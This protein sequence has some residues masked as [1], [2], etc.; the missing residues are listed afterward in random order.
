MTVWISDKV[1]A[2]RADAQILGQ[3]PSDGYAC[4][5][6]CFG[7]GPPLILI[8]GGSGSWLHWVPIIDDLARD[9]RLMIPDM[10]GYGAARDRGDDTLEGIVAGVV[11]DL[12]RLIAPGEHTALAA[13]SFGGIIAGHVAANAPELVSHLGLIGSAGFGGP[14]G[15]LPDMQRLN[16]LTQ[17]ELEAG[18][19]SNLLALMVAHRN[20]ATDEAVRAHLYNCLPR[21]FRSRRIS[22]SHILD[23]LLP[24]ASCS[25]G[26]LWGE[27][28]ATILGHLDD[29]LQ[30]VR[31]L[32]PDAAVSSIPEAG[33]WTMQEAPEATTAT[34][35]NWFSGVGKG[36]VSKSS[37][38]TPIEQAGTERS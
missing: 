19:R 38:L 35:R 14:R 18:A 25:I 2:L 5:W 29:R 3:A 28:D 21:P 20:S 31:T 13:F 36:H 8:H 9:Y 30:H 27:L 12:R 23:E 10:P 32:L 6:H 16:E 24:T 4:V 34:L 15:P 11:R 37:G 1:E 33:H 26:A 22:R 7:A 17:E